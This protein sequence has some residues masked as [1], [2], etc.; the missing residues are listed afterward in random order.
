[1]KGEREGG[2]GAYNYKWDD[3]RINGTEMER[4]LTGGNT[5]FYLSTPVYHTDGRTK[6]LESF[7]SPPLRKLG[8]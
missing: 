5:Q 2:E 6:H 8:R 4:S 3:K 1:M 7:A